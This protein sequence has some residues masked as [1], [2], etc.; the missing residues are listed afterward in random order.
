MS[1]Q[2][3]KDI[4]RRGFEEIFNQGKL[5]A[6]SE[7]FTPD[8]V[9]HDPALPEDLHGPEE[10]KQF[11]AMYRNA[12]PDLHITI[13]DQFAKED[14][15]VTRFTSRGTHQGEFEGITATGQRIAVEGI[16]IDRMVDG[17]SAEAWT[18]VDTMGM[19]QQLGVIPS[20]E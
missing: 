3:N 15:V 20:P 5:D 2:E 12:F 16:S 13:E 8:F 14:K 10:F 19:M 1:D 11:A 18:I 7:F 4:I 9:S 17:K 6:V